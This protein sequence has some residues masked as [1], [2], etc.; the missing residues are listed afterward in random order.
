MHTYCVV[1][2]P[3]DHSKSPWIHT[4][5]AKQVGLTINY[6]KVKSE[7]N[8]FNNCVEKLKMNGVKGFNITLPFKENAYQISTLLSDRAAIAKSVNTIKFLSQDQ[9]YGDN[10]DGV[11]LII[12]IIQNLNYSLKGKRI[13]ILGA[14]G[15]VRGILYPLLMQ[16][17]EKII[18]VN[19]TRDKAK[20]LAKEFFFYGRIFDYDFEELNDIEID[21]MIDG[22]SFDSV[23]SIPK[24]LH[25]SKNSLFYDLKYTD[26]ITDTM[27]IAK[28]AGV[29]IVKDGLGMLIEQAAEAFYVWTNIKPNTQPILSSLENK[30]RNGKVLLF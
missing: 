21:V 22:T 5:F 30:L 14:G 24:T 23:L 1:G 7:I 27:M 9:I 28:S 18:I 15:A 25:F 26:K 4:Q 10:T 13:L 17:P 11:G 6:E 19:R 29:S 16:S 2:N 12:D 8:K 3:I 20:L